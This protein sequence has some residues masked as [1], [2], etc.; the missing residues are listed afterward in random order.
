MKKVYLCVYVILQFSACTTIHKMNT[1]TNITTHVIRLKPGDDLR[2]KI[3]QYALQNNIGAGWLV[4]CAGSLAHY[5]IRYANVE[6]GNTG[7][8]HFEIVSLAG[9]VSKNG[10]HIHLSISDSTGQTIGGHLLK[11]CIV[12]TTAEIVLQSTTDLNF[13]RQKDGSTPWEELQIEKIK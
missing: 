3:E 5:N 8:G 13:K 10:N 2:E 9:T 7:S 1:T 11:G 12:Y 6:N 4:T